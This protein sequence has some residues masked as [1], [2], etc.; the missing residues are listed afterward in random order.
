MDCPICGLGCWL[1][2]IGHDECG[3]IQ[4]YCCPQCGWSES[5][6]GPSTSAEQ[7]QE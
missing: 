6:G 1:M 2:T 3:E 5:D 7:T 4:E